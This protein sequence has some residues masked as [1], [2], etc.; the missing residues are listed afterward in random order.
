[1]A[2]G[3][4]TVRSQRNKIR[5]VLFDVGG[6]LVELSGL[7]ML[8]S[9]LGQRA[10]AEQVRTFWLTS[11][12]VRLFE[13]GK[14]Q[15]VAF[16]EQMITELSL[17][18]GSEEFLTELYT[19]SQRILPGAV[20]LVKRVPRNYV[21]ATLCNSN[22][23]QWPSLMEQQD[24]I[25]AF[26]HHFASHLTGK[27]K[28]DEGAFQHVLAALGCKG[29]ETLFLDDSQLNVAAARRVGMI[30]FHVQGPVE[31][32]QALREAEVLPV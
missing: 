21:R 1:M 15:P 28:P 16:A 5:I 23:L 9:W 24:L 7:A 10:T 13:T 17:S 19:R 27:I 29:P 8:L 22:A 25:G 32:E 20:E 3:V 11:P 12:I 4:M 2:H 26:D 30:A 14:M 31:A 6:V 18:V